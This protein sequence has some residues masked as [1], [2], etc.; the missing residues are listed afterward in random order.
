MTTRT[1]VNAVQ[2]H[3][4]N[5]VEVI[6]ADSDEGPWGFAKN[7]AHVGKLQTKFTEMKSI[8]TAFHKEWLTEEPTKLRKR[9]ADEILTAELKSF[10]AAGKSFAKLNAFNGLL[11]Q[12]H[13]D[14]LDMV[15]KEKQEAAKEIEG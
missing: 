15:E 4:N 2:G 7:P 9:Y 13:Q 10:V 6:T 1:F 3:S 5:L 8:L 12:R 14:A 11:V